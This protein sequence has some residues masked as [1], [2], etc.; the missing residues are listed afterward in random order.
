MKIADKI[1]I[2]RKKEGL[3]QPELG[4]KISNGKKDS[5]SCQAVSDWETEKTRPNTEKIIQLAKIFNVSTDYLLNDEL[6]VYNSL[7]SLPEVIKEESIPDEVNNT[8]ISD[9]ENNYYHQAPYDF[10][11]EFRARGP[12]IKMPFYIKFAL[13]IPLIIF[14][15]SDILILYNMGKG[16]W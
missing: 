14:I 12:A 6:E 3:S 5:V 13:K 15:I 2:L 16:G 9:K 7:V 4:N 10:K 8:S 1:R 11:F